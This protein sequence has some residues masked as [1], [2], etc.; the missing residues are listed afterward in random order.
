MHADAL[1]KA[2]IAAVGLQGRMGFI[3]RM[4]RFLLWVLVLWWGVVLLRRAV[5]WMLR[6]VLNPSEQQHAS[7]VSSPAEPDKIG[8][9]KLVRDPV[10]GVHIAEDR[11][12]ALSEQSG[13]VHFCSAACRDRYVGGA[14]KF[15]SHG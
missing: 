3:S 4:M 13:V 14:K 7:Q 5:A 9:R 15:A 8:S 11:A 10:C 1:Q 2:S 6:G 12:I